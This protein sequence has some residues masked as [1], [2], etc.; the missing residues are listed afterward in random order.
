MPC[1]GRNDS[2]PHTGT[3]I[4]EEFLLTCQQNEGASPKT[5]Y[6]KKNTEAQNHSVRTY[7][8]VILNGRAS[9][10]P[11][12]FL[13]SGLATYLLILKKT[14]W[15]YMEIILYLNDHLGITCT[16]YNRTKIWRLIIFRRPIIPGRTFLSRKNLQILSGIEPAKFVSRG[17]HITPM[18]DILL[19]ILLL[20][21][22]LECF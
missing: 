13:S 5:A 19:L 22:L 4:L 21:L 9:N 2:V 18:P 7:H 12:N 11:L 8:K 10:R 15:S 1:S 14:T 6:G 3:H 17:K 16:R 20:L